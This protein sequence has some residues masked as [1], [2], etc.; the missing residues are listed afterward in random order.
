MLRAVR[1]QSP[2][3]PSRSVFAAIKDMSTSKTR[4]LTTTHIHRIDVDCFL[5]AS[6]QQFPKNDPRNASEECIPFFRSAPACG[7]GNTGH[8]FGA[9]TVRQQINSLTAFLDVGQVYGSEDTKV[10]FLR[11]LTSNEGLLRVNTRFDDNGRELLPFSSMT[12]NMCATRK[13]ITNDSY[14]E[15]VPCF[16]AGEYYILL[17]VL[18]PLHCKHCTG[19]TT[20]LSPFHLT[21]KVTIESM[22]ILL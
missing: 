4:T 15:E 17:K 14:A 10:R 12:T 21:L 11:N 3:S 19:L 8:I 6:P 1:T 16:V 13:R 22:R 5:T 2:V 9:S 7:S 20:R 18:N